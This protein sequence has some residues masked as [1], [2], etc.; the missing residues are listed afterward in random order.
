MRF[1]HNRA[2][3]FAVKIFAKFSGCAWTGGLNAGLSACSPRR[4]VGT[5][6]MQSKA[7]KHKRVAPQMKALCASP[8]NSSP[9]ANP[10]RTA[11]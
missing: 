10:A 9:Q 1:D 5:Q 3:P 2:T 8:K 4:A 6:R 7:G 11:M